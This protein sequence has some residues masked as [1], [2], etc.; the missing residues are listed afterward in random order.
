MSDNRIVGVD[1]PSASLSSFHYGTKNST[2]NIKYLHQLNMNN[3]RDYNSVSKSKES[4]L[5]IIL[6]ISCCY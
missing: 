3:Y 6:D 4:S 2:G 1:P 5:I